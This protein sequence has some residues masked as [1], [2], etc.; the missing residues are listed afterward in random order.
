[1]DD[2]LQT[3]DEK[4]FK[5][6]EE[7]ETIRENIIAQ[8]KKVEVLDFGAGD[9]DSNKTQEEMNK[10]VEKIVYTK[11][12]CKIGLKNQYAQLLYVLVK[13]SQPKTVLE[14]GTCC[15][16]SSIYMSKALNTTQPTIH[17]I[18]GSPQTAQIAQENIFKA[19]CKNIVSH[20]G[21]FSDI[22]PNLLEELVTIDFAF[23]DGHH[24]KDATLAYF[25]QIKPYL[26]KNSIVIFDDISWS[27][28]MKEAWKILQQDKNIHSVKDLSKLGI[29]FFGE[30]I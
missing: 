21:K 29:C 27:D 9:P 11:D 28:G 2:Y 1:M 23:I 18:E 12:L 15:G 26:A 6:F 13:K 5:I 24:D 25:K 30:S 7:I 8:N 22:L 10:G 16:F 4:D 17:T 3:L 20:I 19:G 14:L